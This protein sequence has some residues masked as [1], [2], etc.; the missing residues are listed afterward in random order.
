MIQTGEVENLRNNPENLVSLN[1][2]LKIF[3]KKYLVII[4]ENFK[5]WRT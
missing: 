3:K 5:I 1:D 2:L 4:N